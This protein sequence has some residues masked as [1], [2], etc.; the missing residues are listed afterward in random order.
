MMCLSLSSWDM[1]ERFT[2]HRKTAHIERL[3]LRISMGV[4]MLVFTNMTYLFRNSFAT[5][6]IRNN[7]SVLDLIWPWTMSFVTVILVLF[8]SSVLRQIFWKLSWQV[9]SHLLTTHQKDPPMWLLQFP[10]YQEM[11]YSKVISRL[12][13]IFSSSKIK[14]LCNNKNSILHS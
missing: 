11:I 10:W 14:S 4:T 7:I 5:S 9:W 2:H 13:S 8:V 6:H 12:Y 3:P 1:L